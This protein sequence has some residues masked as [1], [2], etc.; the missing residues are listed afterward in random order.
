MNGFIDEVVTQGT[1]EQEVGRYYRGLACKAS[2][3]S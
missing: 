2:R 1:I 3:R